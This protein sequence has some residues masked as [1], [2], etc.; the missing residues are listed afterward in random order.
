VVVAETKDHANWELIGKCAQKL[1]GPQAKAV[2]ETY[3]EVEDRLVP[4]AMD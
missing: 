3:E 1:K 2:M 4:R